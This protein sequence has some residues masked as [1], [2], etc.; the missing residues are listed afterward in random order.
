MYEDDRSVETVLHCLVR[1]HEFSI[2]EWTNAVRVN[3]N[4]SLIVV[5]REGLE[6]PIPGVYNE[7]VIYFEVDQ[8]SQ[9]T[10]ESNG[11]APD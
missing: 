8:S 11:S 5:I 6:E 4:D 9:N 1:E 2:R 3:K 7:N 10:L